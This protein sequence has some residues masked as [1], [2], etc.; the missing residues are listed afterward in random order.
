M[1]IISKR[2]YEIKG[3]F[4]KPGKHKRTPEAASPMPIAPAS[5]PRGMVRPFRFCGK[6]IY[7]I[8]FFIFHSKKEGEMIK[9]HLTNTKTRIHNPAGCGLRAAGCGLRAAGCGLQRA[10]GCRP[11]MRAEGCPPARGLSCCS[12]LTPFPNIRNP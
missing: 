4:Q 3:K 7:V 11:Y 12:K 10:A 1:Q 2:D 8:R 9:N 5:R 6:I